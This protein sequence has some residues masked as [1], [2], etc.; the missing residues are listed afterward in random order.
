MGV[1]LEVV[2]PTLCVILLLVRVSVPVKLA[3][4]S[5]PVF[6]RLTVGYLV[7]EVSIVV[8]SLLA[9]SSGVKAKVSC[10]P[11]RP[12]LTALTVGYLVALAVKSL[13]VY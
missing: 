3:L 6:K 5:K 12:V 8:F 9:E 10:L 13:F 7:V 2:V 11:E 1:A 4:V